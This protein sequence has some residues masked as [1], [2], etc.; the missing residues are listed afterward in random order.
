M[1]TLKLFTIGFT[2]KTAEDFF[3]LLKTA[4]VRRILDVRLNNVSQLAGFAKR[5]D[6][7]FFL[8]AICK[9]E[10]HHM[11]LL[12]PTKEILDAYR[13]SKQGWP[14]YE[15]EFLKLISD[16][17]VEKMISKELIDHGCLLCSEETADHCHRRLVAEY[18]R[19]QWGNVE[20]FHI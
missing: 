18:L 20:I 3:T 5:D 1:E 7:G 11:P 8:W 12:A 15:R 14:R 16:R 13:K 6:L 10:Y 9:I 19:D 17:Q 2:K 4:K